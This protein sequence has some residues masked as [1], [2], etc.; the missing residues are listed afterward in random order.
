MVIKNLELSEDTLLAVICGYL[1]CDVDSVHGN[2]VKK[3]LQDRGL[4]GNRK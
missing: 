2:N 3:Y 1:N 4:Y